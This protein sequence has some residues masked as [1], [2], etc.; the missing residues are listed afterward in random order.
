MY[1]SEAFRIKINQFFLIMVILSLSLIASGCDR[2]EDD[3]IP[4]PTETSIFL[5]GHIKTPEGTPL[6]NIPVSV[7]FK[8]SSWFGTTVIHKAKGKTDKSGF[9]KIFFDAKE[10]NQS[11]SAGYIFS[12]DFSVLSPND[13]IITEKVDYGFGSYKE[14]WIGSTTNFDFTIPHKRHLKVIVNNNGEMVL[15]GRYAVKNMFHYLKVSGN[16]D[17]TDVTEPWNEIYTWTIKESIDISQ[18]GTTS[19]I[20]PF[21]IGVENTVRIVYLGDETIGYPN[22]IPSGEKKAI[23]VTYKSGDEV[24]LD[25]SAPDFDNRFN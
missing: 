17:V 6:P 15:N 22:G 21:A 14:E 16:I 24:E 23:I 1:L 8:A 11:V 3:L 10:E 18:N 13:Y 2:E 5:T 25:Y 9:Y 20:S 4:V 19:V 12:A 7:D